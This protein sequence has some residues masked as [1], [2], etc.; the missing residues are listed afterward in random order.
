MRRAIFLTT[1]LISTLA[2]ANASAASPTLEASVSRHDVALGETFEL[3]LRVIGGGSGAPDFAPLEANFHVRGVSQVHRTVIVNGELDQYREWVVGLSPRQSG[4]LEIPALGL[5]GA[6]GG[7]SPPISIDVATAQASARPKRRAVGVRSSSGDAPGL[8]VEAEVDNE[9]PYVQGQVMLRV[10][11]HTDGSLLSGRLADPQIEGASMERVG[12]DKRY[13]RTVDGQRYHVIEREF[14]VFPQQSGALHIPPIAFEG[15]VPTAAPSGGRGFGRSRSPSAFGGS[16]LQE[17]EAMLDDDFFGPRGQ[18]VRAESDA[19][20]L[21]VQPRPGDAIG[22]WWLPATALEVLEEWDEEPDVMRVGEQL[23]RSLIIRALGV[24]RDQLPELALPEIPGFKQY[25]EPA[26]DETL[27][28][29]D[30]LASVK[31]QKTVL[32]PTQPGEIVL[33]AIELEW[34]DTDDDLARVARLPE[35]HILVL[36]EDG[37]V[38]ATAPLAGPPDGYSTPLEETRQGIVAETESMGAVETKG[39]P[40]ARV[41]V[42]AVC[43]LAIAGVFVL[44][45]LTLERQVDETPEKERRHASVRRAERDLE[46]ACKRNDPAAADKALEALAAALW[47]HAAVTNVGSFAS[48]FGDT[49]LSTAVSDL[50]RARFAGDLDENWNGSPLWT[51]YKTARHME[52]NTTTRQHNVVLPALYPYSTTS[53]SS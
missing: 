32:I 40:R 52:T 26:V 19:L 31:L 33:P 35:R 51:S 28:T 16:L 29:P 12:E 21:D 39:D 50:N 41:L 24:S 38:A 42:L 11:L 30:G 1:I 22:R 25:S 36:A 48:R 44:Y 23:T 47:P 2:F 53:G 6:A 13:E 34:W 43:I 14:V 9:S 45:R 17:F 37:S 8:F 5:R 20:T 15:R 49:A 27:Q 10:R 7:A 18:L 46:R 4:S 3:R